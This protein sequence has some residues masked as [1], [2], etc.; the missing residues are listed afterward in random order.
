MQLGREALRIRLDVD[1]ALQSSID[2]VASTFVTGERR[3]IQVARIDRLP[4]AR[5]VE[6][7]SHLGM[8]GTLEL[9]EAASACPCDQID[10]LLRRDV[11]PHQPTLGIRAAL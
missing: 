9:D 5:G 2:D 1:D 6:N 8:Y 10:E 11:I 7:G 3:G 4:P